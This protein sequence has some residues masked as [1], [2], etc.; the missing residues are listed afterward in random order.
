MS[1]GKLECRDTRCQYG[2]GSH[3]VSRWRCVTVGVK[4][5]MCHSRC[6]DGA[7]SQSVSR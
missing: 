7:V 5:K 3:S 4:M 1:R 6:Q 2:D